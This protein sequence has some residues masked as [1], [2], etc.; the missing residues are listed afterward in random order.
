MTDTAHT[1][2]ITIDDRTIQADPGQ[3]IL[4]VARENKIAIP[5]LCYHPALKPSGSCI[6]S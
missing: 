5:H 3:T 2:R 4:Q 1:I 6:D